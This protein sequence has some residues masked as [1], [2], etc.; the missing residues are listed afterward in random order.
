MVWIYPPLQARSIRQQRHNYKQFLTTEMQSMTSPD[1]SLFAEF[2]RGFSIMVGREI[3]T[4][5][6]IEQFYFLHEHYYTESSLLL[7]EIDSV[8]NTSVVVWCVTFI[9]LC[10][11]NHQYYFGW[12]PRNRVIIFQNKRANRYV[13]KAL[14]DLMMNS[15]YDRYKDY[16]SLDGHRARSRKL[17]LRFSIR[18]RF[19]ASDPL[20]DYF[21]SIFS[22]FSNIQ[23]KMLIDIHAHNRSLYD[24]F[25]EFLFHS[26]RSSKIMSSRLVS[27]VEFLDMFL[28]PDPGV[29]NINIIE[30]RTG[31]QIAERGFVFRQLLTLHV[32]DS[33]SGSPRL[34]TDG[35]F[36]I[37]YEDLSNPMFVRIFIA[38]IKE[39]MS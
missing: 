12:I 14:Y 31:S 21:L 29:L 25:A 39:M 22:S 6:I 10:Q 15:D 35:S 9:S 28:Q 19:Y 5:L 36:I 20:Y 11:L 34:R 17:V 18:R 24:G 8:P 16:G 1:R 32:F 38:R 2:L 23:V 26:N 33:I 37:S 4:L 30:H 27:K 13:H 7:K 3:Q